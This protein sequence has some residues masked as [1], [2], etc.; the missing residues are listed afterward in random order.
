M[1]AAAM[2]SRALAY[3]AERHPELALELSLTGLSR[4]TAQERLVADIGLLPDRWNFG[5]RAQLGD[6]LP[7]PGALPEELRL[8]TY[9]ESFSQAMHAAHNAAFAD[10]PN[11]IPWTAVMWEQWVTGSRNFRPELSF[12]LVAESRPDEVVAYVQSYEY[13]AY[14]QQTGR[15]EAYVGKVGTLRDHRRQGLASTLL[16]HALHAYRAAGFDE[17]SL[18]VDSHNPTGALGVYRRAGFEVESRWTNYAA[19]LTLDSSMPRG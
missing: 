2:R 6:S 18:D 8:H 1:L 16:T 13:D 11:F 10:H 4:N 19:T 12:V 5:M 17:A 3:H 15:R 9:D 14:F 7:T